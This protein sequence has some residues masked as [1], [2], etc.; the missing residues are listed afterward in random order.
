MHH[1][2]RM[3]SLIVSVA[4]PSAALSQSVVVHRTVSA[5]EARAVRRSHPIRID[6]RLDDP[7]WSTA[8]AI[9]TF[10]QTR[11]AEG[12]PATQRTEV[13]ILY[14]DNAIY[15]GARM[16]DSLGARGV[17]ARLTRRDALLDVNGPTSLTSDKL[18]ITLDAY[19]DHLSQAV[20]QINPDGVIG[21]ALGEGG[22]SPDD[23]WDPIWEAAAHVDSLGWTAEMRIPLSQLGYAVSADR[24][25]GLQIRRVVDRLNEEDV[26]AFWRANEAGGPARFGNLT[27]MDVPPHR[28]DVELTPY[29]VTSTR[30]APVDPGDPFQ[31]HTDETLRAGADL[32][33]QVT[34]ALTLNA[35]VN[36]DFGQVEVDPAVVNLSAFETFFPEKRPFFVQGSSVFDFGRLDCFVCHNAS[37]LDAFDSRRIGRAPQLGSYISGS[38]L[39]AD[40]PQSSTI[41]AATKLTGRVGGRSTVGILE[42]VTDREQA[43]FIDTLGGPHLTQLVEPLTN[44]LVARAKRDFRSGATTAG[45]IVTSVLRRMD[46]SLVAS[47]LRGSATEAGGDFYT[48]TMDRTYSL[49]GSML[50]SNVT[51][52]PAAILRTEQSSAHYFQRPDRREHSDGLFSTRLDSN[53]TYLRGYGAYLRVA[54]ESGNW[55]AET[56]VSAR[57]PGFEVN[58]ISDLSRSDYIW[59]DSN[60]QR[61]W[62]LP[63]RWYRNAGVTVGTQ[64][65]YNYDGDHTVNEP[66]VSANV[67]FRNYWFLNAFVLH[68]PP[69]LDDQI[70]RGG[71]VVR[72]SGLNTFKAVFGTDSRKSV[73]FSNGVR[74]SAGMGSGRGISRWALTPELDLKPTPSVSIVLSPSFQWGTSAEQFVTTVSDP[75]AAAFYGQRA[76]FST[77][78]QTTI[79]LDTRIDWTFTPKLTLQTYIQPFL[80]NGA[81]SHFSEFAHPRAGGLIVYGSDNRS[82]ITPTRDAGGS[83]TGYTVDPDA[84]GPAPVFT[85]GNPN[86]NTRSFIGNAVLRWEYRPGSTLYLVW[87]QQ[88]EGDDVLGNFDLSRDVGALYRARPTNS[89]ALK[90]SYWIGR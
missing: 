24:S 38:S 26:W 78:N 62:T 60:L 68:A 7:D 33:A 18:T 9:A 73:V 32:K 74:Y 15:I 85:F 89:V 83:V 71:P 25:W 28:R 14:D 43:Q 34:S 51:G 61:Q 3:L 17:H 35:T 76:V 20:L 13:R 56:M 2:L 36:P 79:S 81:Y 82:V 67:E 53:A 57:S 59:T 46:D 19:H 88:R 47:R 55:L 41:I 52:T 63:G 84:A 49:E 69:M 65:N 77:I 44:Y 87:T 1:N 29:A 11:P 48:A 30:R 39:Y 90:V 16:Y 54:K 37:S 72:S 21:D 58:D 10:I 12:L 8:P 75:T 6:G 23:S 50:V 4:A 5:P 66:H 27:G 22:S 80:A 42:A 31:R 86:F 40:V 45:L 70:T 64:Q